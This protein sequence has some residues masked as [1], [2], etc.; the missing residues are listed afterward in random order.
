MKIDTGYREA[1]VDNIIAV[2]PLEA[3][4]TMPNFPPF[5][6]FLNGT[7][8]T[9]GQGDEADVHEAA[10]DPST[11]APPSL[12]QL[13]GCM[14]CFYILP[15]LSQNSG[16]RPAVLASVTRFG[17]VVAIFNTACGDLQHRTLLIVLFF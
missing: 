6:L 10:S 14:E 8:Q 16:R 9:D 7:R 13:F 1:T 2:D 17:V 5:C 11:A 15:G 3:E 12:R 4:R